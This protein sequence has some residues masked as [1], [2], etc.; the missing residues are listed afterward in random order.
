MIFLFDRL[1]RRFGAGYFVFFLFFEVLSSATV[2]AGTIGLF[3]LYEEV[4]GEQFVRILTISLIATGASLTYVLVKAA[5]KLR[6]VIQW[7]KQGRPEELALDAWRAAVTAPRRTVVE[8]GWQPFVLI[9]LAIS[10]FF[11]VDFNLAWYSAPILFAGAAV[12]VGYATVLNFFAA[13]LALRPIVRDIVQQLPPDFETVEHGVPLRWKLVG[14]LPLINVITGVVVAGLSRDSVGTLQELGLDV[15]VAVGVAFTLSFELTILLS[16]SILDP[17]DELT[18]ATQRLRAGDLSVRVP[19]TSA[20]EVGVL[21]GNFN[22]AVSGLQEREA[23][24]EAFGS[25][26]DPGIAERVLKE[27]ELLEGEEVEVSILFVDIREFTAFAERSSAREV[28]TL[29]NR[30]FDVVVPVLMKHGGHANK[31]VGD[32]LLGVFGAPERH[33]DHADRALAAACE[34][35]RVVE[36]EF[37]DEVRIGVGVNSGPVMAGSIGG[38]GRLEFTVIGDAVNVA[39]RIEAATRETGDT[40]LITEA[41]RCLLEHTSA[42]LAPRGEIE[43]KGVSEPV[44]VHA[45]E[46][47]RSAARAPE[48]PATEGAVTS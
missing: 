43:L 26:V 48:A 24:R 12:A 5:K 17:I 19:V 6:P 15:L 28:V 2:T 4:D 32:G 44:P 25:Y 3:T 37:G 1:Y 35:A 31:F 39:A 45:P 16:K 9:S 27:G 41:T 18:Q 8:A 38:G 47:V 30:F 46:R 20:D 14:A 29:L 42:E 34:I 36:R 13:E 40:V 23:L 7:V 21:A 11:T 10:V 33:R 22:R